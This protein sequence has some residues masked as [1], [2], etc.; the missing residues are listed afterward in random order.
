MTF[1][2]NAL[3]KHDLLR[4]TSEVH[5]FARDAAVGEGAFAAVPG[6]TVEDDGYLLAYVHD[7]G[8][9]AADLTVLAAR[10]FTGPPVARIHL[11]VR[12]PLG[13]HGSWVPDA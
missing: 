3:V 9:G 11:P 7:P 1:V 10:D 5:G 13:L 12:V 2:A 8:R 6:S 4:G